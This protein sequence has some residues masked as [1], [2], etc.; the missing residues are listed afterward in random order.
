M[1]NVMAFV[2]AAL[3]AAALAADAIWNDAAALIFLARK[4]ID[5]L[6]YIAFWR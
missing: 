2:L 6:Q 5:F 3:I 4:G 1:S